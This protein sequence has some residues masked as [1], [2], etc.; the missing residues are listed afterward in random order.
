MEGR[1][2]TRCEDSGVVGGWL[3]VIEGELLA[4]V[5]VGMFNLV[6]CNKSLFVI[7]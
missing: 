5:E 2:L 4:V 3:A 1:R 6:K 7:R